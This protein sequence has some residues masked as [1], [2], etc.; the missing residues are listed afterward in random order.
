MGNIKS[1]GSEPH[2][3]KFQKG[4]EKEVK[5][6]ASSQETKA[7]S[8]ATSNV[9]ILENAETA[10]KYFLQK[11]GKEFGPQI[12]KALDDLKKEGKYLTYEAVKA[13]ME[14]ILSKDK[15]GLEKHKDAINEVAD[16]F[17]HEIDVPPGKQPGADYDPFASEKVQA[18]MRKELRKSTEKME[19]KIDEA[20]KKRDLERKKELEKSP[21]KESSA[22]ERG[23][24]F[25]EPKKKV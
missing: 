6:T 3:T 25:L 2:F 19:E 11:F 5:G 23:K 1:T 17:P 10:R 4:V 13:I 7:S 18:A 14:G 9:A 20:D 22:R 24:R 16:W 12:A 8:E 15:A 21:K